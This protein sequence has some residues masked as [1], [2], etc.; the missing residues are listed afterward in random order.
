M[1]V[2][3]MAVAPLL[4]VAM[5]STTAAAWPSA[6]A[7]VPQAPPALTAS[8]LSARYATDAQAIAGAEHTAT[9]NGETQLAGALATLRTQHVLF[10]NPAGQG[11]AAMV[12]GNLATATRVA[13][14]VP[15]SDTTLATF[16]SRGSSSPGGGAEALATEAHRLD[17]GQRG[18]QRPQGL[19]PLGGVARGHHARAEHG[20]GGIAEPGD[21]REPFPWVE[22]VCLRGERLRA[23]A[24]GRRSPGEE[25]GQRR[26]RARHQDR[27]PRRGGQVA[28]HHRGHALAVGIEEQ[29]LLG[30]QRGQRAGQLA[31]AVAGGRVF[32]RCDRPGVGGVAGR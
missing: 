6:T 23:A 30:A 27:D 28:D 26:V 4:A 15:G 25:R 21:D 32:G 12:I 16:F 2:R 22:P 8:A 13:I 3:Y 14:L 9:R 11:V 18:D 19:C 20:R 10:F 29:H 1:R 31:V 5:F 17:P 24:G 7:A